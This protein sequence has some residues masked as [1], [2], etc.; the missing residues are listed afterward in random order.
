MN[1]TETMMGYRWTLAECELI[2]RYAYERFLSV[3]PYMIHLHLDIWRQ[4]YYGLVPYD[5]VRSLPG[6]RHVAVSGR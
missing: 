6:V 2:S 3:E 1:A 5:A 4:W